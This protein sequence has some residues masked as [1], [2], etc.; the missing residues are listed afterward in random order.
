[1]KEKGI[2]IPHYIATTV[3]FHTDQPHILALSVFADTQADRSKN[4]KS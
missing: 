3:V 4:Q 1:M 2:L